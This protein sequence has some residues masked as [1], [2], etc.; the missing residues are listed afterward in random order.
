MPRYFLQ[1]CLITLLI[2]VSYRGQ[3]Q[4]VDSITIKSNHEKRNLDIIRQFHSESR[5][6]KKFIESGMM[7]ED[8]EWFVPGP[9][10][11]LPFAG[12]WKGANGIAEFNRLLGATMRYDKVEIK[13]YIVDG[14]QLAAIFLGEGIAKSTGKPFKSEIL[15]LNTF[16]DGKIIKVRNFYDTASYVSA[17][18]N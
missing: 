8:V 3:S 12:L 16:K 10:E 14:D 17:V 5:Y 13:E 11:I 2:I 15:R 18:S 4:I 9:K 6:I 7:S 1:T